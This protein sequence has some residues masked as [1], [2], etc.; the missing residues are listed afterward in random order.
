MRDILPIRLA[1]VDD[2]ETIIGMVDEAAAW[3]GTKGTDQW[4]APWP[5]RTARDG[6]ILRGIRTGRT[7][8]VK[9]QDEPVATITCRQHGNHKLWNSKEQGDPAVYVSRL[10]VSRKHKGDQIGA[11]LIDW[12][13]FQAVKAWGAQWIRIDVWTTNIALHNYYEKQK[14][15]PVRICQFDDPRS[16]PS[17]ALFQKP[18]AAIDPDAVARFAAVN[19]NSRSPHPYLVS[20]RVCP[21][22]SPRSRTSRLPP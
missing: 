21:E 12:A 1:A 8:I 7:W 19:G 2:V 16:Y 3:L 6:R 5:N 4:A 15:A 17:A 13:G 11:A 9:E 10:I 20:L 22:P 18:T 14:F